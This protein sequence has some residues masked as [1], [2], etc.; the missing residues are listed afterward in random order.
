MF[1]NGPAA[2]GP[3]TALAGMTAINGSSSRGMRADAAPAINPAIA[4]TW[5]GVHT[6]SG[7]TAPQIVIAP[8]T[9]NAILRLAGASGSVSEV[10]F[11]AGA[12]S[13]WQLLRNTDDTFG[14]NDLATPTVNAIL[15][16]PGA[17][18]GLHTVGYFR[19]GSATA[20]GA[21][22]AG[23]LFATRAFISGG[24]QAVPGAGSTGQRIQIDGT[25]GTVAAA[26]FAIGVESGFMWFTHG[27]IAGG[28]NFYDN[29]GNLRTQILTGVSNIG[30]YSLGLL[31][32]GSL[33]TPANV[34]GGDL[35][36]IRGFITSK[37]QVGGATVPVHTF[38]V[39][40]SMDV[41]TGVFTTFINS[42][43]TPSAPDGGGLAVIWNFSG[44]GGEVDFFNCYSTGGYY[45]YQRTGASTQTFLASLDAAGNFAAVGSITADHFVGGPGVSTFTHATGFYNIE[46]V[47][48]GTG[49]ATY[50]FYIDTSSSLH[51]DAVSVA[52]IA[53]WAINGD[54]Q[55]LGNNAYKASGTAWINPSDARLKADIGPFPD[56]LE[57]LRRLQPKQWTY[58]DLAG[59]AARGQ[60]GIGFVAQDLEGLAD[61]MVQVKAGKLG[62]RQIED[63]RHYDGHAL[64]F[65]LVNAVKEL[66]RENQGL[67]ARLVELEQRWPT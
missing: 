9:G 62:A 22:A 16:R 33:A 61:Y 11:R 66:D 65:V 34:T 25:Q 8:A 17:V 18:P 59:A 36:A 1:T 5:T 31:N 55:I 20:P 52:Q 63:L 58:N 35:T 44:G 57:L 13:K 32:V 46:L 7:T 14:L 12:T 29:A 51:L 42:Q 50:G 24:A 15:V 26:D 23:D 56:G 43:S 41:R 64:P 39:S 60:Q 19:V 45:W 4:P 6:W 48:T 27:S 54:Y 53:I 67:R 21:S 2:Y 38:E 30:L 28:Y 47:G 3:P 10:S 49:A 40:G 37:L